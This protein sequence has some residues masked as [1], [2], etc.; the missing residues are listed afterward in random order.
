MSMP[1][2]LDEYWRGRLAT[3]Q[4]LITAF[5]AAILALASGA[6]SYELD[7][8]QSR[9][10][11]TVADLASLRMQRDTLLNELSTLEARVNGASTH[12]IPGF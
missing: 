12:L 10:K 9:A 1:C 11:K 8:G 2:G 7:T 4:A 3:V 6:Q 5:D